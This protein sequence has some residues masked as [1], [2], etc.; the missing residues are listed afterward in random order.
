LTREGAGNLFR[1]FAAGRAAEVSAA[2][3]SVG[4]PGEVHPEALTNFGLTYPA[5]LAGLFAAGLLISRQGA[6]AQ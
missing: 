1:D 3:A 6:K 4:I 5:A 2:G